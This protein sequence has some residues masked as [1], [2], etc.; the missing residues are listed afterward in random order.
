MDFKGK[1]YQLVCNDGYYY[2]GSTK[3]ELRKRLFN[4]KEASLN[5]PQRRVYKHINT[6]G[7]DNVN[8]VLIEEICCNNRDELTKKEYEHIIKNKNDK[9]CLNMNVGHSFDKEYN[10]MYDKQH[11]QN[12]KNKIIE[13]KKQYYEENKDKISEYNKQ[14]REKHIDNTKQYSGKNN[15]KI[16]C[17]CGSIISNHNIIVHKKTKKHINNCPD[18][19]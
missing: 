9:F 17:E 3:N 1:I 2:I 13:Y 12:N 14:Y 18:I 7:W 19:S 4:H 10:K 5:H 6:I 11:R 15:E 8:I 16:T